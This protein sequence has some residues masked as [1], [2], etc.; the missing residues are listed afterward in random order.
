MPAHLVTNGKT[1]YRSPL[2]IDKQPDEIVLRFYAAED[3]Y[4]AVPP[5]LGDD[6]AALASGDAEAFKNRK[7]VF[8]LVGLQ[9]L[10]SRHL[11]ILVTAVKALR[12]WGDLCLRGVS[13]GM[14]RLLEVTQIIK[15]FSL[16]DD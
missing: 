16:R 7:L 2:E 10:S 3:C 5:N 6:L 11:G 1:G 14:K 9:G 12:P 13:P 8:D 4:L 15:L